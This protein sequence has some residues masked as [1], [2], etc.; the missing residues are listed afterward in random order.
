M[1]RCFS[2]IF[3]L[4]LTTSTNWLYDKNAGNFLFWI[5]KIGKDILE[6]PA[7][8]SSLRITE[9]TET[10]EMFY[11]V[12]E[13]DIFNTVLWLAAQ[14]NKFPT[15][16]KQK[17]LKWTKMSN[18]L[19]FVTVFIRSNWFIQSGSGLNLSSSGAVVW[20]LETFSLRNT[21]TTTFQIWISI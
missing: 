10:I 3:S 11:A 2:I 13:R 14:G 16:L 19:I 20:G 18:N 5:F 17:V 6:F 7:S 15:L 1:I 21:R 8:F 4:L 12:L 9:S